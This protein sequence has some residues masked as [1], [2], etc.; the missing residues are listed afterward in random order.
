MCGIA[1]ILTTN[2]PSIAGAA[3]RRMVETSH[4]RGPDASGIVKISI[5]NKNLFLGHTRLAII[6]LSELANQPMQDPTTNSWLVYNGE[7]YNF[8]EMREEI[9][10]LGVVLQSESD[11]EVLLQSL[12]RWGEEAL[13]KL[14][15][16]YAFG[17]W[18]GVKKELILARDPL[19]IKPLYYS[20]MPG[21]FIFGSEVK[22]I[23][24]SNLG[25]FT[26]NKDAVSS[27]LTYGAIIQPLTIINE[28]KELPPG[29][30]LKV[31]EK[32]E[33]KFIK[34][35]WSLDLNN[36]EGRN[37]IS[38]SEAV[39]SIKILLEKS[40]KSHLISDVPVGILLSGGIDSSLISLMASS[41]E[42]EIRLLTVGFPDEEFSEVKY[43]QIVAK[44]TNRVHEVI[45]MTP[46]LIQHLV[47]RALSSMDQPTVDGINTYVISNVAASIGIK[48]L[49]SGLGG[50][51]LFGGYTTFRNVPFL[52]K[53]R[54][55]LSKLAK[56]MVRLG[57]P[58]VAKWHKV[59]QIGD[60]DTFEKIYLVHRCIRWEG[61]SDNQRSEKT[62]PREFSVP[63][64][65]WDD[66]PMLTDKNDFQR[67]AFLEL[68]FYLGNQLL[69]DSDIFSMAN[70]V[71][72]RVPFLDLDVVTRAFA[73]L[74]Q[75]NQMLWRGKRITRSILK[76]MCP[77]LPL[78]RKKIG[79][80]FPWALWLRGNLKEMISETLLSKT[81]YENVSL[82][83]QK[84]KEL[85][86][87]FLHNHPL[88]SWYQVWSLF[89]L[90]NWQ[91]RNKISVN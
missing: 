19:G 63:N 50:D 79:F 18:N 65:A 70:S 51:E 64:G 7:I 73:L 14:R 88:V 38:F 23:Q 56:L 8:Q 15:G 49:L 21:L 90:L 29:S 77:Q 35:Y 45:F 24:A 37:K 1:G 59:S 67:V 74:K 71:E 86:N 16:M 47:P 10:N 39:N 85:L 91:E 34:R 4:H 5:E 72:L 3:M 6:D 41:E 55:L 36:S 20:D 28:I 68:I 44:K 33:I 89:V 81:S 62:P 66:I 32:G 46:D 80:T 60:I 58:N 54:S 69:R 25:D 11:T 12:S 27:F 57:G 40:V 30:I 43:A 84:G 82:D 75:Y 26:L 17:F 9:R 42:Q 13:K 87:N 52:F 31:S 22:T 83:F 76:E 48:T 2:E 53:H 61:A 78:N